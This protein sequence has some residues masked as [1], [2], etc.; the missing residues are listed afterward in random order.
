MFFHHGSIDGYYQ[1]ERERD[2]SF[3]STSIWPHAGFWFLW[4]SSACEHAQLSLLIIGRVYLIIVI[5]LVWEGGRD[6]TALYKATKVI[7]TW[8]TSKALPI[9]C[10]QRSQSVVPVRDNSDFHDYWINY[11]TTSPPIYD[12][13]YYRSICCPQ[14]ESH[15]Y[16]II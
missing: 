7:Y 12:I 2:Q 5:S 10:S 11:S 9:G 13:V 8:Y 1:D 4:G 14:E 3:C 6:S 15:I 16:D